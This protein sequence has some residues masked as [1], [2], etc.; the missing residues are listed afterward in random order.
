[1]SRPVDAQ[2]IVNRYNDDPKQLISS[3]IA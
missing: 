3:F 1:L 2:V